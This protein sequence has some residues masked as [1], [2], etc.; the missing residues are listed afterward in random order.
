MKEQSGRLAAVQSSPAST[1]ASGPAKSG[2]LSGTTGRPKSGEA[3]RVAI[4]VE[5]Q[6]G[7]LRPQP[8]D[9]TLEQRNAAEQPQRLVAAAHAARLPAGEQ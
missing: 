4:G 8:L 7:D 9:H 2:T 3:G 1:P 5:D 6:R